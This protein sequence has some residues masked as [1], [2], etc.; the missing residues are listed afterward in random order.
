MEIVEGLPPNI[1]L[2]K[3]RFPVN[4][5]TVY[6]YGDKIYSPQGKDLRPDLIYHENVHRKQQ[7]GD[8]EGWWAR[9]LTDIEFRLEQELEAYYEQW[10]WIKEHTNDK[11][12]KQALGDFARQLASPLYQFEVTPH[13]A[14][15]M[16][17]KYATTD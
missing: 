17:R 3:T 12:G 13:E 9:Y 10:Q 8:P 2:I 1:E 15:T 7:A 16:I 14:E 6:A 5:Y 11:I 4:G